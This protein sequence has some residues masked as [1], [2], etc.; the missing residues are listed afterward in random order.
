VSRFVG[1]N[2]ATAGWTDSA[3][4]YTLPD[5]ALARLSSKLTYP[6]GDKTLPIPKAARAEV[7]PGG[8]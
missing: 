3:K 7:R 4:H 1:V 6:H 2:I 8:P 5:L